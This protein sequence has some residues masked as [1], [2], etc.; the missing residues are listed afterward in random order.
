MPARPWMR[1]QRQRYSAMQWIHW[2]GTV[3]KP[4]DRYKK[5]VYLHF[6]LM[7]CR[8]RWRDTGLWTRKVT[9]R[10]RYRPRH[11]YMRLCLVNSW[12]EAM[13][14]SRFLCIYYSLFF[15]I[16]GVRRKH[17][18][19]SIGL[20]DIIVDESGEFNYYLQN[21]LP[22]SL[23]RKMWNGREVIKLFASEW[24]VFSVTSGAWSNL[25][26]G[27][28]ISSLTRSNASNLLAVGHNSGLL[29]LYRFPC[30]AERVST[31]FSHQTTLYV[32]LGQHK[33]VDPVFIATSKFYS[34][35]V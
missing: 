29:S 11:N 26:A 21:F 12:S 4:S 10:Q 6:M 5:R 35:T 17:G 33:L 28:E 3:S 16:S 32:M 7:Q 34:A 27:Q 1:G 30:T 24:F 13:R 14:D 8:V 19:Y 23:S 2:E 15:S 25:K 20:L 22:P 9:A 18:H 31:A